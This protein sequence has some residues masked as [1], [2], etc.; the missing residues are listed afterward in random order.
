[1]KHREEKRTRSVPYGTPS[2]RGQRKN[3]NF[4]G[5]RLYKP[6]YSLLPCFPIS[7]LTLKKTLIRSYPLFVC[8]EAFVSVSRKGSSV[9]G[10]EEVGEEA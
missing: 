5:L 2:V 10:R 1:M 7:L 3:P 8:E 4:R 6:H 9:E